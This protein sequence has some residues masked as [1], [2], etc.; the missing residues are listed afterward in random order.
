MDKPGNEVRSSITE[1]MVRAIDKGPSR[2]LSK[3]RNES[4]NYDL[5]K[6]MEGRLIKPCLPASTTTSSMQYGIEK[7][8]FHSL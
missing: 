5:P 3:G 7:K 2:S 6:I 1:E 8:V 4:P